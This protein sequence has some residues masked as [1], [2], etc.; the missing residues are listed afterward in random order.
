MWAGSLKQ[1]GEGEKKEETHTWGR[2]PVLEVGSMWDALRS[3]G[4]KRCQEP[5][6]NPEWEQVWESRQIQ[7]RVVEFEGQPVRAVPSWVA[8]QPATALR[9]REVSKQD[10]KLLADRH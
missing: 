6:G 9:N 7:P 2:K 3:L 4:S 1:G 10:R 8:G 5:K